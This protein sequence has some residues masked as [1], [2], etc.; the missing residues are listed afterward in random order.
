MQP[1][2]QGGGDQL[3]VPLLDG[4]QQH[5]QKAGV[6]HRVAVGHHGGQHAPRLVGAEGEVRRQRH[7]PQLRMGQ[8][9]HR[10][11]LSAQQ[12]GS[13]QAAQQRRG[14]IVGVTLDLRGQ[15]QQLPLVK[16]LARHDVG[17]HGAGGDQ[18]RRGAKAPAHGNIRLNVDMHRRHVTAAQLPPHPLIGHI[19]QILR[20]LILLVTAGEAQP[21]RR[22]KR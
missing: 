7:K 17:R 13:G 1:V 4:P 18:R 14:Q 6:A 8:I 9:L 5:R 12:H 11:H 2:L 15:G 21:L 19:G 3:L 22:G 10:V 20:C 16:G